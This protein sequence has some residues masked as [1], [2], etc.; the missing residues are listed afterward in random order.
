MKFK[1]S[2]S[3]IIA[4]AIILLIQF[5][6]IQLKVIILELPDHK[7]NYP[8]IWL[9]IASWLCFF[10]G[11]KILSTM[12]TFSNL[13]KPLYVSLTGLALYTIGCV[14]ILLQLWSLIYIVPAGLFFT[15]LGLVITGIVAIRQKAVIGFN[16][17]AFLAAGLYPFL[18]MFPIVAFTGSPNYSVNYFWGCAWLGLGIA[19][20]RSRTSNA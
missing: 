4:G 5:V 17:F 20:H 11:L 15:A 13:K 19:I 9:A 14:T 10:V 16:R 3:W 1:R 18:F 6:L 12:A 8:T 7:I 2:G